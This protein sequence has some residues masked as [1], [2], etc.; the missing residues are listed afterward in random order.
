MIKAKT[1]KDIEAMLS[2]AQEKAE[3]F[4]PP[5]LRCEGQ[6]V[7]WAMSSATRWYKVTI[8]KTPDGDFFM[9]CTCRGALEGKACY[10]A[11]AV[12]NFVVANTFQAFPDDD[13]TGQAPYLKQSGKTPERLGR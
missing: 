3:K 7:F 5:V 8:G 2:K 4:D 1:V 6:T 11:A 12:Y 13:D 9:A 10:H